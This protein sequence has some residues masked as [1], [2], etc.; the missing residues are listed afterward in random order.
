M[1][2]ASHRG[3]EMSSSILTTVNVLDLQINLQY[4]KNTISLPSNGHS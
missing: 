4:V 1:V 2:N 3:L